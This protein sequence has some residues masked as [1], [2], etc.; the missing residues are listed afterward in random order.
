[1]DAQ[2]AKKFKYWQWRTLIV[3]MI[4]YVLYYFVRKN[5]SAAIPALE[6]DLGITKTQLGIFLTLH[7]II[8]GFSR[9][10]NGFIADR[11]NRR[12]MMASGLVLSAI[13]NFAI[14]FSPKLD[15][16]FDVI[17]TE[18]KA[19]LTLVYIIGSLWV[20]NGYIHG[21]G[22]PPCSSLMAYWF[23]PSELST[24]QSIWNSSHSIGAGIVVALCGFFLTTFGMSAWNLCFAVPGALALVGAFAV[25]FGLRD[26]PSS[27]G[28]PE[29]EEL[30]R[31]EHGVQEQSKAATVELSAEKF[32]RFMK[33]M[34]FQNK[35]VWILSLSNFCVYVIRFTI[36]DWGTSFLTQ[37]K[38]FEISA[39][40]N[41][42]A[43]SELLGGVV[44]TLLAGW[45]TDR[46][47]QSKSHR[48]CLIGIVG[49]TVCFFAFWLMPA[50]SHWILSAACIVLAAF[51]IYIPQ[52]LL[53]VAMTQQATKKVCATA[54]GINGIFGYAATTVAGVGFGAIAQHMGWNAVFI[55]AIAFG[56]LGSL[57]LATV[58]NAPADGYD[59]AEKI[60]A[61]LENE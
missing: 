36:L 32:N 57:I 22:F 47:L 8:Y 53:G 20:L 33:K 42:V 35:I 52:A 50:G 41:I 19:T 15:G 46:Y 6:A 1:M 61:E 16:I 58:W 43:S 17:D 34:V 60:I 3:L 7:G 30:E 28:L 54:N 31:L 14:C 25:Y 9:F 45:F 39:A 21:M 2:T 18:G 44:G 55:V 10:V 12:L 48:T 13:V 5:F 37:F 29:V 4:G 59:K 26:N 40:A 56:V 24:K 11:A 23:K 27:L 49:A 51:F 38:H